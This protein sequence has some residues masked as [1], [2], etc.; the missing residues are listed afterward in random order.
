VDVK[1]LFIAL[2]FRKLE[3]NFMGPDNL[4][5]PF[6]PLI[7]QDESLVQIKKTKKDRSFEK[8]FGSTKIG[9]KMFLRK[10]IKRQR[11]K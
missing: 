1:K 4:F 6:R 10:T 7:L 2:Y 5:R 9:E 3:E 11:K 8:R